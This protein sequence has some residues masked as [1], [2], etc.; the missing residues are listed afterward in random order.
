MINQL[1]SFH[2]NSVHYDW[3]VVAMVNW[4]ASLHMTQFAVEATYHSVVSIDEV[5]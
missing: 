5:R 1:T 4:V 2:F 3:L